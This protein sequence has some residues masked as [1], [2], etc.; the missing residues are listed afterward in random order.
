VNLFF[1]GNVVI[2]AEDAERNLKE[3]DGKARNGGSGSPAA[4][5]FLPA[6]LA[7]LSAH[8]DSRHAL[9]SEMPAPVTA[10]TI[11]ITRQAQG[12]FTDTVTA[13]NRVAGEV[14]GAMGDLINDGMVSLSGAKFNAAVQEWNWYFL[15]V[16]RAC[17]WMADTLG[18][19][20][21]QIQANEQNNVDLAAGLIVA[22]EPLAPGINIAQSNTMIAP[23][24]TLGLL[25]RTQ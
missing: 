13:L 21:D 5:P 15:D 6:Q 19:T 16:V 18:Q 2:A 8:G 24:Q 23:G 25:S 20:A 22:A 9:R 14:Y 10:N 1:S 17:Q 12:T 11:P 4:P 7:D 3:S